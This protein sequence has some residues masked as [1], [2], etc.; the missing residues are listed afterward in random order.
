M[1]GVEKKSKYGKSNKLVEPCK[2][3]FEGICRHA[4]SSWYGNYVVGR[5]L[6]NVRTVDYMKINIYVWSTS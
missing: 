3:R 4:N 1:Y 5:N 6:I 2:Y